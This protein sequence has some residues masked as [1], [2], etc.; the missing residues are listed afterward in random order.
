MTENSKDDVQEELDRLREEVEM[1]RAQRD[2]AEAEPEESKTSDAEFDS[3]PTSQR[4]SDQ[5]TAADLT[6]E[7]QVLVEAIDKE[8][9]DTNPVTLLVVFALGA[10]VGR[11]LPR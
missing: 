4:E 8:L 6:S 7:L 5:Y 11:M 1:L 9:K 2:A 3:E 10:F